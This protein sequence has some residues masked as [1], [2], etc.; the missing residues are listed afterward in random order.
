MATKPPTREDR[1]KNLDALQKGM[2]EW[3]DKEIKRLDNESKFLRS[4]L[5]GRGATKAGTKNLA[6]ASAAAVTEIDSFL[7]QT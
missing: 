4:V 6:K 2:D 5:N 1:D 7:R 3:A